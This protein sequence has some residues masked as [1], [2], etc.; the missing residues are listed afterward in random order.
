MDKCYVI[1]EVVAVIEGDYVAMLHI[2]NYQMLNM[3]CRC[4]VQ[5]IC[6][7]STWKF[8]PKDS[9]DI[10]LED[11]D[12]LSTKLLMQ[13]DDVFFASEIIIQ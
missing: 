6:L 3:V 4:D 1:H 11:E 8:V 7:I 5:S 2:G 9:R 10:L 12:C 13:Y